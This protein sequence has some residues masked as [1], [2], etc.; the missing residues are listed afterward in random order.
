MAPSDK[1]L[2]TFFT[3]AIQ[4][5]VE[6]DRYRSTSAS[7]AS[8]SLRFGLGSFAHAGTAASVITPWSISE[9]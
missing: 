1:N 9:R 4:A 2:A 3:M 5:L 8:Q 7:P 6:L